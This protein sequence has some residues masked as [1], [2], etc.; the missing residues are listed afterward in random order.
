VLVWVLVWVL[1]CLLQLPIAGTADHPCQKGPIKRLLGDKPVMVHS[2][3]TPRVVQML[4]ISLKW[5][6][7]AASLHC[8]L[9]KLGNQ[10]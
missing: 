2:S 1:E 6:P 5:H 4:P 10:M 9:A 8:R 3:Q 7:S